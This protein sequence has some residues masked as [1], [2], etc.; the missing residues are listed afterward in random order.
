M[1]SGRESYGARR[2]PE[3]GSATEREAARVPW[4]PRTA[5]MNP[6]LITTSGLAALDLAPEAGLSVIAKLSGR[7]LTVLVRDHADPEQDYG[8]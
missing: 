1:S 6:G 4:M 8:L 2:P 7:V 5:G 3:T